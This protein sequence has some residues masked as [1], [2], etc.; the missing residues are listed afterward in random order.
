MCEYVCVCTHVC[1][2]TYVY[3]LQDLPL[4]MGPSKVSNCSTP[5]PSSSSENSY[6]QNRQFNYVSY[7]F[8]KNFT[9]VGR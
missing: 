8:S 1:A 7:K 4:G 3:M 9:L 5:E 2:C 6:T